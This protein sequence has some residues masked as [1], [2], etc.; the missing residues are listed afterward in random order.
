[1][2]PQDV[3]T[4]FEARQHAVKELQRLVEETEGNE[5][6]AEQ[7]SEFDRQNDAIDSLD[8]RINTGLAHMKREADANEALDN[9]RA[10]GDLTAPTERAV[11]PVVSDDDLFRQLLTGEIRTFTSD[12]EKRDLTEGSATAGGNLVTS[13]LYQRVM[14]KLEQEGAALAA[15]ATLISTASGEDMLIPTVTSH[16]TGALVAEGGA[17]GESDPAFGQATLSTYKFAAIVD[18]SSELAADNGV[19]SFN[20]V[21]FVGDQGGAAVGR[22]LSA[23]W[24]TG[25]GSSRPQG[26]DNCTTGVTAASATAITTDELIDLYHSVIAP[27]RGNAA[28]VAND[29]TL[30]A[31]RKLKDGNSQ[32]M[33]Q[34]GL[35]AGAPDSLLGR[36][37]HADTNMSAIATG[38]TTMVFGDFARGYFAR[39]AGGVRVEQTNADKWTTDLVS[40]RFIVR[41]GGVLV[42]TNALRKLVQA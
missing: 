42:D 35:T 3:Q 29:S 26:F 30:K 17:I 33:W 12:G 31:V 2:N 21:N 19:G 39:I 38:N 11:A 9:F 32:Y 37:V 23:E 34:P 14:D 27:Y 28:W 22:A 8:E 15:G 13:T 4:S 24:T 41:G 1:M 16:T 18:V 36:P 6:S 20:V 40:V 5:F 7:R 10:M 25:S